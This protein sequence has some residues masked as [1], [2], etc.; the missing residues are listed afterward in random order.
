M[1]VTE[2]WVGKTGKTGKRNGRWDGHDLARSL[3]TTCAGTYSKAQCSTYRSGVVRSSDH[4]A[5]KLPNK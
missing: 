5:A 2:S 4:T 3:A 1:S